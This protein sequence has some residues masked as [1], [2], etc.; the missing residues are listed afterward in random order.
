MPDNFIISNEKYNG[1]EYSVYTL[2]KVQLYPLQSG[3][4]EL[5]PIEVENR[6]TFLKAAYANEREGEIFFDMLRDFA[7]AA[8]PRE[9]VEEQK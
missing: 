2:R 4:F 5:E 1:R 3:V 9:A 7:G 6:I 8:S